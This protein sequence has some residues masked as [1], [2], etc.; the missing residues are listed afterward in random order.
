MPASALGR[1][2]TRD[3]SRLRT[4]QQHCRPL[5]ALAGRR[6]HRSRP[7]RALPKL[8]ARSRVLA[9]QVPTATISPPSASFARSPPAESRHPS[10][11]GTAT[12]PPAITM[13]SPRAPPALAPAHRRSCPVPLPPP[14]PRCVS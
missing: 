1:V 4:R 2:A 12:T 7:R 3:R 6:D 8:L 9:V 14:V 10:A 11:T 13:P 5:R